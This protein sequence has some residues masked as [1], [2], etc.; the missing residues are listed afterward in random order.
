MYILK[1]SKADLYY[2]CDDIRSGMPIYTKHTRQARQFR[3]KRA[4]KNS[5]RHGDMIVK[6]D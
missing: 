2:K 4:A 1:W 5:M 3:T 6:L